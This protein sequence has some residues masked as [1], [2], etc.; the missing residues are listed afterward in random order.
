MCRIESFFLLQR[1]KGRM[2]DDAREF[3][4]TETRTVINFFSA[5][6]GA[7][8]NSQHSDRKICGICTIECHPEK[9]G[10]PV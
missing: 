7:E 9:L 6:Q 1:L 3:N 4:N 5:R 10:G 8:G 2:S